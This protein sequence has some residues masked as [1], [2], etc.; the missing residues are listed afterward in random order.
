MILQVSPTKRPL[1]EV[2][3]INH[4]EVDEDPVIEDDVELEH[5]VS[6]Q[7]T[8]T[9]AAGSPSHLI[10]S[11]ARNSHG[12]ITRKRT[13]TVLTPIQTKYLQKIL[14][15]TSFPNQT[16]REEISREI[17]IPVRTVQIWFQNQRQKAKQQIMQQKAAQASQRSSMHHMLN[18]NPVEFRI[19][20]NQILER[21]N[22]KSAQEIKDM[23]QR[24]YRVQSMAQLT[25]SMFMHLLHAQQ[26]SRLPVMAPQKL[27]SVEG[28]SRFTSQMQPPRL[29]SPLPPGLYES[30]NNQPDELPSLKTLLAAAINTPTIWDQ[31]EHVDADVRF[32]R[33][34]P[35]AQPNTE[36]D[37]MEL[38]P[39]QDPSSRYG[40]PPSRSLLRDDDPWGSLSV[41]VNIA[42]KSGHE[43]P[44]HSGHSAQILPSLGS[45]ASPPCSK[46]S[47]YASPVVGIRVPQ[48]STITPAVSLL[49]LRSPGHRPLKL[50][51]PDMSFRNEEYLLPPVQ[52]R[53]KQHG[54]EIAESKD[55]LQREANPTQSICYLSPESASLVQARSESHVELPTFSPNGN[56]IAFSEPCSPILSQCSTPVPF[57]PEPRRLTAGSFEKAFMH[58]PL[59]TKTPHGL[60]QVLGS[61]RQRRQQ[62]GT[63][64]AGPKEKNEAT[65]KETTLSL[66]L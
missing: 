9:G 10:A 18:M 61:M 53:A 29:F 11:P 43:S 40:M 50:K 33:E 32:D 41:L 35:M 58:L 66:T 63:R 52:G 60:Y 55:S 28:Q 51:S 4:H 65:T 2:D 34:R 13:R 42:V 64:H 6:S 20:M 27:G 56:R 36:R 3:Q 19:A 12:S 14:E 15:K 48:A 59:R 7:S 46:P 16:E 1:D 62:H 21:M 30:R 8:P 31:R 39:I 25:P 26:G 17:N 57:E 45:F 23:A 47:I 24:L 22:P 44:M 5:D 54:E 37:Q 38:E 49:A